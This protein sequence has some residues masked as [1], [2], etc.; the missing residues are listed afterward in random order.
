MGTI[1]SPF[2]GLGVGILPVQCSMESIYRSL[3]H[4]ARIQVVQCSINFNQSILQ[5]INF[6]E[7]LQNHFSEN[8]KST[9][10]T[11]T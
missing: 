6:S 3:S 2:V 7:N 5:R 11:E 1:V 8:P 4:C 9:E 10:S